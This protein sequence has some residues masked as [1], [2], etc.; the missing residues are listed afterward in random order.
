MLKC[1]GPTPA[2]MPST[3]MAKMPDVAAR[4][5]NSPRCSIS[6]DLGARELADEEPLRLVPE[7]GRLAEIHVHSLDAAAGPL[8][9]FDVRRQVGLHVGIERD[10]V[11]GRF[12]QALLDRGAEQKVDQL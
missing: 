12:R 4:M 9:S 1:A 11:A 10:L 2:V 3:V 5:T 7:V 6:G 8:R